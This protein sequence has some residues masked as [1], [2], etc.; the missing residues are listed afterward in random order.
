LQIK[1][2][3]IVSKKCT[4]V[5]DAD[6]VIDDA[7]S[8]IDKR[9][10]AFLAAQAAFDPTLGEGK[11]AGDFMQ[12]IGTDFDGRIKELESTYLKLGTAYNTWYVLIDLVNLSGEY[13]D[14]KLL[15]EAI[16]LLRTGKSILNDEEY[17]FKIR[18]LASELKGYH[19][20][21]LEKKGGA[22]TPATNL[23][24]QTYNPSRIQPAPAPAPAPAPEKST[25][26]PTRLQ[27]IKEGVTNAA[28]GISD[29][30]VTVWNKTPISAEARAKVAEAKKKE[31]EERK[32]LI[33]K[34]YNLSKALTEDQVLRL[35]T[36]TVGRA[37]SLDLARQMTIEA[38][39][40]KT[41]LMENKLDLQFKLSNVNQDDVK[42][43]NSVDYYSSELKKLKTCVDT[44]KA[45]ATE[46]Y[47]KAM[48]E[49]KKTS[50]ETENKFFEVSKPQ[51]QGQQGKKDYKSM[52][53][54]ELQ[55]EIVD[56]QQR[57][58]KFRDLINTRAT[59]SPKA[60]PEWQRLKQNLDD[61]RKEAVAER[62]R[63]KTGGQRHRFTM[64]RPKRFHGY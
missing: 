25:P 46:V 4:L 15:P 49:I 21:R 33:D 61:K 43:S 34:V 17:S 44:S 57:S 58:D 12:P 37:G 7:N 35:R 31:T 28:Q 36:R 1:T 29:G 6:K 38:E 10:L 14:D 45:A 23:L 16:E 52:T 56:L 3:Q 40:L 50:D 41:V 24:A 20:D 64:R 27:R 26:T 5:G 54:E 42:V 53:D 22:L 39:T 8:L 9:K 51:Q 30:A 13:K 55:R 48:E 19:E 2:Q 47:N 32:K 62:E 18:K 59:E 11:N 63:R 60:V